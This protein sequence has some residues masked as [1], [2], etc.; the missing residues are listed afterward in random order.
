M[1]TTI[2]KIQQGS[3]ASF[4][5]DTV[6]TGAVTVAANGVTDT[7][8]VSAAKSGYTPVAIVGYDKTG[9]ASGWCLASMYHID[10]TDIKFQI[11]NTVNVEASPIIIFYVMY[12]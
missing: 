11:R 10:G 5:I 1:T 2:P 8:T 3:S 4:T 6:N 7:Q 12:V 9:A